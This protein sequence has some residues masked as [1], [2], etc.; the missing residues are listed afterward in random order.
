MITKSEGARVYEIDHRP[1]KDVY[2]EVLGDFA[3][4]NMPASTIEFPLICQEKDMPVARSMLSV[5]DDGSLLYGGNLAE[6][7]EVRFGIGSRTLVNQYTLKE[8]ITDTDSLQACFIYSCIAR[9]QFLDKELEKIFRLL[10]ILHQ[11][12]VFLPLESFS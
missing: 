8:G 9:K 2:A 1:I 7:E 11:P 4:D 12:A 6:G 3:V 10:E 5:F